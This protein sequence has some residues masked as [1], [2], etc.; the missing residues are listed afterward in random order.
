MLLLMYQ[1]LLFLLYCSTYGRNTFINI[2]EES[3]GCGLQSADFETIT[4]NILTETCLYYNIPDQAAVLNEQT[5]FQ[6]ECGTAAGKS[7]KNMSFLDK[8][9]VD[10]LTKNTFNNF[11]LVRQLL[12]LTV[13][14]PHTNYVLNTPLLGAT[15]KFH[16]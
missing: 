8:T 16:N 11:K 6:A 13:L 10:Q 14:L 3:G 9:S 2:G 4:A 12:I 5:V 15:G 1:G 7:F